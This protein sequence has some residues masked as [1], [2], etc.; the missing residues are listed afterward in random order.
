[1]TKAEFLKLSG[2]QQRWVLLRCLR[3]AIW[4]F[5]HHSLAARTGECA[6]SVFEDLEAAADHAVQEE[7][8]DEKP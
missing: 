6:A 3:Y 5:A 4:C 2:G 8:A 7:P 1:M